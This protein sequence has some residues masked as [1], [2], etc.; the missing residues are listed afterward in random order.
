MESH[1]IFKVNLGFIYR[2]PDISLET[3]TSVA[4]NLSET[5]NNTGIRV[6]SQST[7][8]E[9]ITFLSYLGEII[10][11]FSVKHF[12][13]KDGGQVGGSGVSLLLSQL[14]FLV[15]L[16]KNKLIMQWT[17]SWYEVWK[18]RSTQQEVRRFYRLKGKYPGCGA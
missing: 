11:S 9:G 18:P 6:V 16:L 17:L 15:N 14:R 7:Q 3:N 13:R 10:T 8:H 5:C 2:K 1:K 4:E 12:E